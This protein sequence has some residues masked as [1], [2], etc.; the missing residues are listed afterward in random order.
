VWYVVK[1]IKRILVYGY[2][3]RLMMRVV[4]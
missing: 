1:S 4:M 2:V 3:T